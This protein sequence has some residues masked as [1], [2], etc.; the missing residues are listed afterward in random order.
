MVLIVGQQPDPHID[1]V[2]EHL[3]AF[4]VRVLL[5]NRC[6]TRACTLRYRNGAV[7]GTI[8]TEDGVAELDDVA[9]VW[10]RVKPSALAEFS[11][12]NAGLA[13]TFM[14]REWRSVLRSLA[15]LLTEVPWVNPLPEHLNAGLKPAQLALAAAAGLEVPETIITN[16]AEEVDGLFD[17]HERVVYKTLSSFIA[18]PDQI[19]YTNPVTRDQVRREHRAIRAAPGIFQAY[20]AKAHEL[21]VT[22]VDERLFTVRIDSQAAEITSTDWRRSQLRDMYSIASLTGR[23]ERGIM[24]FMRR[25][26]LRYGAF[27][28]V[29]TPDGR[30]VFLECNPGGQWLW[31]ERATGAPISRALAE[32]LL[33]SGADRGPGGERAHATD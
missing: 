12:G 25:A 15:T 11:G 9:C 26:G 18:P 28:F 17:R 33:S 27:D 19:I 21:R 7:G 22:V 4:G 29:V 1:A 23:T 10:W 24:H 13:E 20:V 2:S 14:W 32:S 6:A 5:L 8:V 30:E 16:D 3:R 31:L